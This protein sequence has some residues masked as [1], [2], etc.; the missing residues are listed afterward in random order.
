MRSEKNKTRRRARARLHAA[1][2]ALQ[3]AQEQ[4]ALHEALARS[5]FDEELLDAKKGLTD[6]ASTYN[7]AVADYINLFSRIKTNPGDIYFVPVVKS[8]RC[9][10]MQSESNANECCL[11]TLNLTELERMAVVEALRIHNGNRTRAARA[12]GISARTLQRKILEFGLPAIAAR[13]PKRVD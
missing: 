11:P 4:F 13:W 1:A 9:G 6:A 2:K 12:L 3:R 7:E 8:L 5:E 10:V